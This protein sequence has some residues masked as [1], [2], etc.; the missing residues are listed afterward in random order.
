[1]PNTDSVERK[2]DQHPSRIKKPQS[3]GWW[4]IGLFIVSGAVVLTCVALRYRHHT[5]ETFSPWISFLSANLLNLL[6]LAVVIA[7]AYIYRKQWE[8]MRDS[9]K[10]TRKAAA[11]TE[12]VIKAAESS[13][14]TAKDSFYAGEAPYFGVRRIW[15][16]DFPARLSAPG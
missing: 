1:M 14:K 8:A 13:A 12:R 5:P 16:Q 10:E 11:Q 4:L 15:F 9:L 3:I 7:Q 6:L 2:E